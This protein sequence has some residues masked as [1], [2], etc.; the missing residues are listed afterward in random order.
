MHRRIAA[1]ETDPPNL[2]ARCSLYQYS[3]A[4]A[5]QMVTQQ[6]VLAEFGDIPCDNQ[7]E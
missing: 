1:T 3:V 7:I 2:V 5:E 4:R 6:L